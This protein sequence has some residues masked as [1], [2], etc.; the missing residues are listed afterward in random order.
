MI[1]SSAVLTALVAIVCC[2]RK[3]TAASDIAN[4]DNAH[5]FNTLC[6]LIRLPE[7]DLTVFAADGNHEADYTEILQLNMSVA[8]ES[9]KSKLSVATKGAP[10][11]AIA[12]NFSLTEQEIDQTW[13]KNWDKWIA[14]HDAVKDANKQPEAIKKLELTKLDTVQR[15]QADLLIRAAAAAAET[16]YRQAERLKPQTTQI[17]AA[18]AKET[19]IKAV[20]GAAA[21]TP[22]YT[23]GQAWTDY[24]RTRAN[25]CTEAKAT[26]AAATLICLCAKAQTNGRDEPCARNQKADT[27]WDSGTTADLATVFAEVIGGC[28]KIGKATLTA[29]A[30]E[31]LAADIRQAIHVNTH[32]G[33][34]GA[35][36][37]G[38][39]GGTSSDG[40]CV[41][42]TGYSADTASHKGKVKWL[43]E[44]ETLATTLKNQE[45]AISKFHQV[46]AAV[47]G[48]RNSA[49]QAAQVVRAYQPPAAP[50][51]T[52]P[53]ADSGDNNARKAKRE[54][55][56][57][58][59]NKIVKDTEC[60]TPCKWDAAAKDDK[61]CTLS[62]EAKQ[63]AEKA[64]AKQEAGA[65][66]KTTNTT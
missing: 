29:T 57:K 18:K 38:A 22:T 9:W 35:T 63:A 48:A 21:T 52:S 62:D 51:A 30:L 40:I 53:A 28:P 20:Y 19:L 26:S 7:A 16:L 43:D 65:D 47:T 44:L 23:N 49:F 54:E 50:L 31:Q 8:P 34:L 25:S 15:A 66:G 59:C 12:K 24:D 27:T 39:C 42:Y 2:L 6:K 58:E 4:L 36:K 45:Q 10:A 11:A 33:F 5:Q 56:E 13:Q 61:K 14:A 64:A 37:T 17:T 46:A 41:K 32:G 55:A 60:N 1:P 3:V